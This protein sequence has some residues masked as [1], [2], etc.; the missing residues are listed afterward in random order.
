MVSTLI[1]LVKDKLGD[2]TASNNYRSI[3]L[4]R[5]ILKVFDW[6]V[7]LLY[8]GVLK[9][10]GLQFGFQQKTSTSM[11]TW[12]AVETIEYCMR[13]GADVYVCRKA[14]D[15][16]QYSKLFWKLVDKGIPPIYIRL[17]LIMCEKQQAMV[18][19]NDILSKPFPLNNGVKQGEVMSSILYCIYTDC[20]LKLLRKKKTDCWV[21]GEYV[22]IV[23]YADDL[24]LISPTLDGLQE[25]IK[26]CEI[27][28]KYHNLTFNTNPII[29]KCKT[30]C[31]AFL[32]K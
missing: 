15:K 25:M 10:D 23:T 11:C 27:Y 19:W 18:R 26:T 4:S 8:S 13:N 5:L 7:L 14:F 2:I 32:K 28:G 16:V 6:V 17:L 9:V 3:A 21:N 12:L 31:L 30:K 1:P 24:L 29:N 22:G 20:L